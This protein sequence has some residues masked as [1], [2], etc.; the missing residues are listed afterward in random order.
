M[1]VHAT[2]DTLWPN[3]PNQCSPI[4]LF[5]RP[6]VVKRIIIPLFKVPARRLLARP[7]DGVLRPARAEERPRDADGAGRA[8]LARPHGVGQAPPRRQRHHRQPGKDAQAQKCIRL[9][10]IQIHSQN[11]ITITHT[12]ICLP[13]RRCVEQNTTQTFRKVCGP[14][15]PVAAMVA[16][17]F[18]NLSKKLLDFTRMLEVSKI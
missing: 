16:L 18:G 12:L 3:F 1:R 14:C 8:A 17:G 13:A 2:L 6:R 4:E 11:Q 10:P 15:G 9:L 7:D 5:Q